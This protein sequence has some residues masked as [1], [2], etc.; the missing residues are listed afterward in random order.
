LDRDEL[1]KNTFLHAF[2]PVAG[3][4]QW[5]HQIAA[6]HDAVR[7][8]YLSSSPLQLYPALDIFLRDEGFPPGSLHLRRLDLSV[9]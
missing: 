8:H 2:K 3:M 7:F 6:H 5:Y 9:T 4:S 1:I